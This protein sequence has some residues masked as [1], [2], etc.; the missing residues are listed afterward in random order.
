MQLVPFL[1]GWLPWPM[2]RRSLNIKAALSQPYFL[3][4]LFLYVLL[5]SARL[6]Q[7]QVPILI[8]NYATDLLCMPII[9]TLCLAGVRWI[10][11]MPHFHLSLFMIFG[12]T[13]YYI[14]FFEFFLPQYSPNYTADWIDGACYAVGALFYTLIWNK[15][16]KSPSI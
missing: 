5:H 3:I 12:M 6:A 2:D 15:K 4:S 14:F 9:L 1:P 13:V 10:K 7:I 8:N 11:K 16:S